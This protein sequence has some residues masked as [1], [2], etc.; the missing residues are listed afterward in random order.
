MAEALL[1]NSGKDTVIFRVQAIIN[2]PAE[3]GPA[4]QA[5]I[6]PLGKPVQT[7]G[8]GLQA[9]Y[10]IYRP[11]VVTALMQAIVHGRA[12][13]YDLIG[14]DMLTMDELI[15]LLNRNEHMAI[16]H[17]PEWLARL[18]SWFV[19]DLPPSFVDL[20]FQKYH[21]DGTQAVQEFHLALT[22]LRAIWK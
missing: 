21:M 9:M 18:L 12:G 16:R 4:E 22:S 3:P 5:L 15:R 17:T 2:T 10:T 13:S 20:Y 6:A 14:P 7:L 19:P 1:R 11:D 8:N